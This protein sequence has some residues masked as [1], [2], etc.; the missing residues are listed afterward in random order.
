MRSCSLVRPSLRSL[1]L[2]LLAC[3]AL[4]PLSLSA[5]ISAEL[6]P[7]VVTEPVPHDP[8]DPAIWVH[9]KKPAESLIFGTDKIEKLGG[10]YVFNLSGK[11]V[12]SLPGLDRPNNVD[13]VQGFRAGKQLWDLAVLTER[14]QQRLRIFRIHPPTPGRKILE[15]VGENEGLQLF[16]GESG[17]ASQAMGIALYQRPWDNTTFAIVSRKGGPANGYLWQYE[18]LFSAATGRIRAKKV[19]EFGQFSGGADNEV[20]AITVDAQLGHV[21]YSDEHCCVRQYAADPT[22]P[23]GNKELARFATSGW[24]QQREGLGVIP[25]EGRELPTWKNFKGRWTKGPGYIIAT[26]QIPDASRYRIFRRDSFAMAKVVITKADSTD[27]LDATTRSLGPK[28][29]KGVVV[30]MNSKGKNFWLFDAEA[31]LG[32]LP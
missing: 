7:A 24:E 3:L 28:F 1:A 9:P 5:Q 11:I 17:R 14:G 2:L 18:L 27:G 22:D 23:A 6:A 21:Y 20:E 8:D 32:G 30:V 31:F 29:P 4:S 26:D 12:E 13:I 15:E 10:L 19:R 16:A 25:G